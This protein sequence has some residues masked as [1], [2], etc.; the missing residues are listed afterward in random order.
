M[1]L[2]AELRRDA[3]AI[4]DAA[5]EAVE[6]AHLVERHFRRDGNTIEVAER[7]Y[8]LSSY[9]DVYV[10]GAGKAA[11]AMGRAVED[12]LAERLDRGIIIVKYDHSLPLTKLKVLQAGHPV[13][14]QNG[15]SATREILEIVRNA[16][17]HDLI[18][19]LLSGGASALMVAPIAGVTLDDKQTTT[20]LLLGCGATI[21]EINTIRKHISAVK[22]GRLA[23]EAYP[24]TVVTLILSDVIG[25]NVETVASGPFSRDTTTFATC[26]EILERYSLLELIPTRVRLLLE[27]GVRG[28]IPETPKPGDAVFAKVQNLVIGNNRTALRG[29]QERAAELGYHPITLS[30]PV[31][32]EARQAALDHAAMVKELVRAGN[33]AGRPLCVISGGETIV[34]V[35]GNGLGGRNQEFALAAAM[36]IEG[37]DNI[38]I[39]SGGTDGTDGPTEAAGAIIDGLTVR[40]GRDRGLDPRVCLEN[41]DSFAFLKATGDLLMTGPTLTNVMDLQLV[42]LA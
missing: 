29:A 22:G 31:Q 16:A 2:P 40:R 41:N 26:V 11:A 4:F 14:D 10:V 18:V 21:R 36:A 5:L 28:E 12:L 30:D 20:R 37:E 13:P 24:A 8:D 34:T 35:R 3:R 38:V 1:R 23:Q 25:D 15:E 42:L 17:A 6:P 32:G 33:P 39:L 27:G 19:C 7:R 9:R